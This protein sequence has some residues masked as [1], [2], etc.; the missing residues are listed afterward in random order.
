MNITA[1]LRRKSK[2]A[3]GCS[4]VTSSALW[5]LPLIIYKTQSIDWDVYVIGY[6][7]A[8]AVNAVYHWVE[9]NL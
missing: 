2:K 4:F 9:Y 8:I 5:A 6:A 3:L 7:V 1:S